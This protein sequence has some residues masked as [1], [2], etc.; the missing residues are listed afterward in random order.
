MIAV[1][2]KHDRFTATNPVTTKSKPVMLERSALR[3]LTCQIKA[4]I[5]QFLRI[6]MYFSWTNWTPWKGHRTMRCLEIRRSKPLRR[7]RRGSARHAVCGTA[8]TDHV[9]LSTDH[10]ALSTAS[11]DHIA[12][13]KGHIAA[14]PA[15]PHAA[16]SSEP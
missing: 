3:K 13:S 6:S 16:G 7:R 14:P 1:D 4:E 15:R 5:H 8:S 12:A 9:A 10:I 11:T 2:R